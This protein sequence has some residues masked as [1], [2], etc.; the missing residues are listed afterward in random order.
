M[1]ER[2]FAEKIEISPRELESELWEMD[3]VQQTDFLL[4]LSQRYSNEFAKVVMQYEYLK[5]SVASELSLEERATIIYMLKTLI[6]YLEVK[7]K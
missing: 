7:R 1:I 4:A 2:T 5:D 6:D 3:S